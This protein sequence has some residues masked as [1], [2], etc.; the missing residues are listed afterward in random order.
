M[1]EH[2]GQRHEDQAR[3]GVRA[4]AVGEAGRED[5][6]ARRDGDDGVERRDDDRLARQGA[7]ASDVAAEDRHAADAQAEGEERL[8]HGGVDA[9]PKPVRH[10]VFK[11]RIQV[12]VQALLRP[13]QG[14]GP[15]GQGDHDE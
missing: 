8:P 13:G 10:E 2:V 7:V 3:P 12:E 11:I 1:V 4:D 6:Q 14:H 9:V 15:D 5:D